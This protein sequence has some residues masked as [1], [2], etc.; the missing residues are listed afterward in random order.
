MTNHDCF[1]GLLNG[2]GGGDLTTVEDLKLVIAERLRFNAN[3]KEDGLPICRTVWS[4][5]EYCDKR[6]S[7]DLTRFDCC[8]MC[9][10]KIEWKRI[11]EDAE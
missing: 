3:C 2:Y 9:G 5:K 4:L 6:R 8:P 10:K 11:K 1:I 7:T